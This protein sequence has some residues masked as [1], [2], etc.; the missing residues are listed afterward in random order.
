MHFLTVAHSFDSM[1]VV[2]KLN[3]E[4]FHKSDK[5]LGAFLSIEIVIIFIVPSMSYGIFYVFFYDNNKNL[6]QLKNLAEICYLLLSNHA[7]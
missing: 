6:F 2:L 4:H 5:Q 1:S 7:L 3:W